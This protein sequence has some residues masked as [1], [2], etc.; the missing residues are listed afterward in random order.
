MTDPVKIPKHEIP[1]ELYPL[2]KLQ[3]K[4]GKETNT[5]LP[6]VYIDELSQRLGD[7]VIVNSTDTTTKINIA[8]EPISWG[9]LR[10]FL[11]FGASLQSIQSCS[12]HRFRPG[13]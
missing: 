11:Q 3:Q 9:K 10:L 1:G 8:Y 7:L 2:L 4:Q 13:H 6:I 12:L 5:Y